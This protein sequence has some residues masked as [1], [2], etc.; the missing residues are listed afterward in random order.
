[1]KRIL[2]LSD[3]HRKVS[4]ALRVIP[5]IKPDAIIHLG[6]MV[7]DAE[8]IEAYFPDIPLYN[9]RG[10]NDYAFIDSEKVFT[11]FGLRFYC[12]HGHT[13][14]VQR[15]IERAKEEDCV[16]FLY[17]HTHVGKCEQEDGIMVMNPGSITRPRDGIFSFGIIEEENGKITGCVCPA[18]G[19]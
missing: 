1:M 2:V 17:G 16:A 5:A 4:L 12:A 6:D 8:E 7:S 3:T 10:N 13:I 19:Y 14:S 18:M 9:V 11:I 15:G